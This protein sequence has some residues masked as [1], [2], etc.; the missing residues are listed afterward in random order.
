M[1]DLTEKLEKVI[2]ET[3]EKLQ[4]RPDQYVVA[5]YKQA[6]DERLGYHASTFCQ[7]TKDILGAKRYAGLNASEQLKIISKNIKSALK[8]SHEGLFSELM[9]SIRDNDFEGLKFEEIYIDAVYLEDGTPKQECNIKIVTKDE[10][11]ED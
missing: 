7:V 10:L 2:K 3:F 8:E 6:N 9:N 11:P 5:I 1:K 4:E